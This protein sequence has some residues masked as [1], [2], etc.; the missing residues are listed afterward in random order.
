MRWDIAG[1]SP[2]LRAARTKTSR[3]GRDATRWALTTMNNACKLCPCPWCSA[4]P[5]V[6]WRAPRR[7]TR[8]A[9]KSTGAR[10]AGRS[11]CP[12]A[13]AVA[14]RARWFARRAA[15]AS[16][17]TTQSQFSS[18][19]VAHQR[20]PRADAK[21]PKCPIWGAFASARVTV[22]HGSS[23]QSCRPQPGT[24]TRPRQRRSE[25]DRPAPAGTHRIPEVRYT[26]PTQV[27]AIVEVR[28]SASGRRNGPPVELD[29]H[30]FDDAAVPWSGRSGFASFSAMP[31]CSKTVAGR[32]SWLRSRC[33]STPVSLTRSTAADPSAGTPG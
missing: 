3:C 32:G 7:T 30:R 8:Q 29:C 9:V 17:P 15:A 6:A 26:S 14:S 18:A 24:A 13:P 23:D 25:P 19:M 31:R 12:V 11:R 27:R 28:S 21:P 5:L 10:S 1:T 4:P 33:P 2:A 16:P 22:R 20:V